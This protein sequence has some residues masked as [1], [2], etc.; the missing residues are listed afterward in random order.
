M[1][2]PFDDVTDGLASQLNATN[3]THLGGL[4]VDGNQLVWTMYDS[5]DANRTAT[6]SHGTSPLSLSGGSDAEGM[7][8]VGDSLNPGYY[9][10]YMAHVPQAWQGDLGTRMVTGQTGLSIIS[11]TSAGPALFGF[12]PDD[13][14]S[15]P[16]PDTAF[17]Y[18]E[19]AIPERRLAD[20]R[21]QNPLYNFNS[22]VGGVVFAEDSN[23]VVFFGDHGLGVP[24]YG[25][26]E[27]CNDPYRPYKN[28]HDVGGNY[29]YQAWAYDVADFLAVK[30]GQLQPWEVQ[31]LRRVGIQCAVCT[32]YSTIR[33]RWL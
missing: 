33:W 21:S 13:F 22:H 6:V 30:N 20:M 17:V 18:Y 19:E 4:L 2:Q 8:R 5:Y 10:G 12:D 16:A 15:T 24:C 31:P 26:P 29:T 32:K 3:G 25:D 9:A 28:W 11:R 7:F 23:S 14:G 27:P 1:V